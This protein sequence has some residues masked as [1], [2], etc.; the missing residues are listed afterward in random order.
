MTTHPV[1]LHDL[2]WKDGI[3]DAQGP[4]PHAVFALERPEFVHWMSVRYVLS[5]PSAPGPDPRI[6]L[7]ACWARTG[8]QGFSPDGRVANFWLTPGP[9]EQTLV[10]CVRDL[11]DQLRLDL[12]AAGCHFELREMVLL[13]AGPDPASRLTRAGTGRDRH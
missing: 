1:F 10:F 9:Q 13:A 8:G 2:S 12:G 7:Q 6:L 4:D 11:L 3:G 5:G